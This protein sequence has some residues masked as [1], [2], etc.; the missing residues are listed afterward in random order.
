MRGGDQPTWGMVPAG[1]SSP[2]T[3]QLGSSAAMRHRRQ[4]RVNFDGSRPKET[5]PIATDRFRIG[6]PQQLCEATYSHR[7]IPVPPHL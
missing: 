4:V 5:S 2:L 7:S 3:N 1:W 6:T